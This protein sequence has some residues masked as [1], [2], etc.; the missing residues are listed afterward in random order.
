MTARIAANTR[1]V[2]GECPVHDVDDGSV[3]WVD[4]G[5]SLWHRLDLVSGQVTT[6]SVEPALT[7]YAPTDSGD[8]IGAFVSGLARID[9]NGRRA[10]WL[11]QPEAGIVTNRFNDAGTDPMG[12]LIAGTMNMQDG[13]PTGALYGLSGEDLALLRPGVGIA[14]TIAFSPD[15]CRIYTADSAKGELAAFAYDV[16]TGRIG[17]R[18]EGF[19]P[20]PNLPGAPDGSAVDTEGCLWN[21]RWDGGCV[22]RLAPDGTTLA[23][24]DLPV[25]LPTSCC[26]VGTSLYVTTSTWDFTEADHQAQ[27]LAGHLLCLDVNVTG[28]PRPRFATA[29]T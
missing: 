8:Y 27:P 28:Q 1:D 21:A 29:G 4:I 6:V 2:L 25:R 22:V 16:Q 7:A 14:N 20:D 18:V 19:R 24:I 13:A 3:R 26:F 9:R 23:K 17:P 10:A 11:A 15:G 5:R 12:R